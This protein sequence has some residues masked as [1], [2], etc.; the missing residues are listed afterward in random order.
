MGRETERKFLVAGDGWRAAAT[1]CRHIEQCYLAL[2]D[3]AQIRIRIVDGEA[4]TLTI[5]SAAT[6]RQRAEF[7]YDLPIG[8]ARRLFELRTGEPIAKTRHT[9]PA[10]GDRDWEID[11]FEG[12]HAGLVLAEIELADGDADPDRPDWLGEEVTGDARYYNAALAE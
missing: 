1:R 12:R 10:G 4:A 11:V 3:A 9:V 2:T 7:E 6:D 8:E 5:K